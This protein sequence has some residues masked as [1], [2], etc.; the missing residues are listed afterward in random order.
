MTINFLEYVKQTMMIILF[1]VVGKEQEQTLLFMILVK[2]IY[3]KLK[4]KISIAN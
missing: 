3:S 2:M 1:F 4:E